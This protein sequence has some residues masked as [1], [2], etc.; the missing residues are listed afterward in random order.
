MSQDVGGGHGIHVPLNDNKI[1]LY[2]IFDQ[3]RRFR[4]YAR[5]SVREERN[6]CL[7]SLTSHIRAGDQGTDSWSTPESI[8]RPLAFIF[9]CSLALSICLLL[10]VCV[11][12]VTWTSFRATCGARWV[13]SLLNSDCDDLGTADATSLT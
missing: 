10:C 12:C 6:T 1:L 9:Y 13:Q 2:I 11:C 3:V 4:R 5:A 7:S 8:Q